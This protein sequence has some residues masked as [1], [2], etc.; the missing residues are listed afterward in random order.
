MLKET[1]RSIASK[2][3]NLIECRASMKQDSICGT[4]DLL[5]YTIPIWE[6]WFSFG[7]NPQRWWM[8][9][10]PHY[11]HQH[12]IH[13]PGN[14]ISLFYHVGMYK[15]VFCCIGEYALD[16]EVHFAI[17]SV[18]STKQILPLSKNK[19]VWIKC[20]FTQ[21]WREQYIVDNI[22]SQNKSSCIPIFL[23]NLCNYIKKGPSSSLPWN[24]LSQ[25]RSLF[26]SHSNQGRD[27]E[28]IL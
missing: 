27:V 2:I 7:T 24:S 16:E 1:K 15:T 9:K 10:Y 20:S 17:H 11:H 12:D 25:S 13:K 8:K 28:T 3:Q 23:C 6:N 26:V 5:Q 4:Q 19:P 18:F 22:N 14:Q 21:F